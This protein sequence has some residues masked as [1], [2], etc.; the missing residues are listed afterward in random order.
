MTLAVV[1]GV[2]E[3]GKAAV[4]GCLVEGSRQ[5]SKDGGGTY[6]MKMV[7]VVTAVMVAKAMMVMVVTMVV[8][9]VMMVM[10]VMQ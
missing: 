2:L 10:V 3:A 8:T 1:K 4:W 6:D 9:M 7:M 5:A